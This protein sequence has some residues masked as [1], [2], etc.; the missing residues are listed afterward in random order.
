MSQNG[1]NL[2]QPLLSQIEL[3]NILT[4]NIQ[5]SDGGNIQYQPMVPGPSAPVAH[6]GGKPS[7]LQSAISGALNSAVQTV[8]PK[9]T[10]RMQPEVRFGQ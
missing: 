10:M 8:Q 3:Y 1:M 9:I 7:F 6:N 4:K 5:N 2:M